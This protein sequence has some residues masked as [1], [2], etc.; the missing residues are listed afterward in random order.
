MLFRQSEKRDSDEALLKLPSQPTR[1]HSIPAVLRGKQF[2]GSF[3]VGGSRYEFSYAPAKASTVGRRLQLQ[4]RATVKDARGQARTRDQVRA[5][6]I[7]TQGGIGTAPTRPGNPAS[8]AP[9]SNLPEVESTGGTSFTGVLYLELEPLSD[10]ALGVAADL[11]R[12]QLN[13]RF[14]PIDDSERALQAAY[15]S[16]VESLHGKSDTSAAATAVNE[17]NKLLGGG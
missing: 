2:K 14:A 17:L 7:A 6:L 4:G 9:A 1:V 13:V 15:S 16:I 5:M 11:R 10:N 8:G 12:V 3:E